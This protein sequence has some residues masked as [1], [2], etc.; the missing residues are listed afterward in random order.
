MNKTRNIL[1]IVYICTFLVLLSGFLYLRHK[2]VDV[3]PIIFDQN[4]ETPGIE[5]RDLYITMPSSKG[6]LE[7]MGLRANQYDATIYN[8]SGH[9][10]VDWTVRIKLP[11]GSRINDSWSTLITEN[12]D[13]TVTFSPEEYNYDILP[14]EP[15]TFGFILFSKLDEEF[16]DFTIIAT[17]E[18]KM[19]EFPLYYVLLILSLIY[20]IA[21][22]STMVVSIFARYYR[23][24]RDRDRT[25]IVQAIKTFSNFIDAK[26]TYTR[27]HSSRV[28]YYSKRLA[29]EMGMSDEEVSDVYYIALL[30]DVGKISISDD[31][32]N[33]PGKL[34]PEE[35]DVIRTHTTKGA[36]ILR[37]FTA[38][39]S[40]ADGAMY[41]HERYDGKGYPSGLSGTDIP[42]IARI[43]CVADAYDAMNSNRCYR[44]ALS[45]D[46]IK[47]ELDE[48]AGKQFDP[49]IAAILL[50][51][52]M[53][54]TLIEKDAN[55][56]N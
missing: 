37:D 6:W 18:L 13:G 20:V 41:H 29:Q 56:E 21:L 12:P 1:T 38:I 11:E 24:M 43:I 5:Q 52:L 45:P 2:V 53:T 44:N 22:T 35:M 49:E 36:A 47:T 28:A 32:L 30:H 8:T 3:E 33:K 46:D 42:L 55:T 48:N 51:L 19:K 50:S 25:I 40:V 14:D 39:D 4:S 17:P 54:D 26:D 23:K 27:G 31:I 9:N 7:S 10:F 16:T 15:V 34:T